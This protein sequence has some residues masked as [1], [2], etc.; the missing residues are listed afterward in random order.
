MSDDPVLVY[1]ASRTQDGQNF[2]GHLVAT[3]SRI[4][5]APTPKNEELGGHHWSADL[6]GVRGIGTM[7]RTWNLRDGGLR[8][9]LRLTMSDGHDELFVVTNVKRAIKELSGLLQQTARRPSSGN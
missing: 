8:T 5:F 7:P 4:A 1:V 3:Q 9:R 2:G 6:S